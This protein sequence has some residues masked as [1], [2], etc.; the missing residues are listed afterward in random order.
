[1]CCTDGHKFHNNCLN[2]YWIQNPDKNSICP[3][4]NTLPRQGWEIKCANI[5]DIHSG[6]KRKQKS[7]KFKKSN[8]KR[9]SRKSNKKRVG[10]YK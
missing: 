3:I 6:G 9:K 1:M 4:S 2:E 8:K 7:R 5:N 10:L